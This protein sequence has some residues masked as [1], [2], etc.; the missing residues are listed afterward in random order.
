MD[1]VDRLFAC[2]Y[3]SEVFG[4]FRSWHDERALEPGGPWSRLTL[5]IACSTEAHLFITDLN[6]SPFNVGTRL[7]LRDLTQ[8]QVADLNR[9]Y[10]SPIPDAAGLARYYRLVGGHPYLTRC[11]LHEMV[12]HG[13]SLAALEARAD[14]E[15][16][17]FSEHLRRMLGLLERDAGLRAAVRGLVDDGTTSPRGRAAVLP[18][19]AFYRL[20]SAGVLSGDAPEDARPRCEL[21]AA[22]LRRRL[23]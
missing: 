21:Y 5:A 8:E 10:G 15:E 7:T 12:A 9:R 3:A 6:Q 18:D 19:A 1:E 13:T 22:Y 20:R 11:G 23:V 14:S 16:W 17:I 4:L 2:P